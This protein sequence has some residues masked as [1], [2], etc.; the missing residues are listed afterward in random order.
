MNDGLEKIWNEAVVAYSM[1]I[2]AF[3]W[4]ESEGG[5]LSQD[6][7]CPNLHLHHNRVTAAPTRSELGVS[8]LIEALW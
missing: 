3:L 1:Y 4:K 6:S 5:N 7:R 2:A 8:S